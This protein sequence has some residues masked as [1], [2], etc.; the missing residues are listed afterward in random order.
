MAFCSA[1]GHRLA[2]D[3][4]SVCDRCGKKL[5][6]VRQEPARPLENKPKSHPP[7]VEVDV[8]KAA[9]AAGGG[10]LSVVVV[11]LTVLG[12]LFLFGFL[13]FLNLMSKCKA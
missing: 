8:A 11:I 10:C 9:V 1:C 7:E 6:I 2:P 4:V 5:V 12:V 13:M 3:A